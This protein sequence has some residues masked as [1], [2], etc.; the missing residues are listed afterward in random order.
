MSVRNCRYCHSLDVQQVFG[1]TADQKQ[2]AFRTAMNNASVERQNSMARRFGPPEPFSGLSK[3][4]P[5]LPIW[6][7]LIKGGVDAI[8]VFRCR[9][10]TRRTFY[11]AGRQI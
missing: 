11:V 3:T 7:K 10:C 2:I 6:A 1:Q 9:R 8:T 4:N 5:L